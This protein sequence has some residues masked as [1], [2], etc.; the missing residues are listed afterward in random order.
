MLCQKATRD[1]AEVHP[2][3]CLGYS[4]VVLHSIVGAP[5]Q[6]LCNCYRNSWGEEY[7]FK[8][9]R[10]SNHALIPKPWKDC[11]G[12][13]FPQSFIQGLNWTEFSSTHLPI[14][15]HVHDEPVC[16]GCMHIWCFR[17]IDHMHE[18]RRRTWMMTASSHSV[19]GSFLTLGFSW[20]CHLHLSSYC[21]GTQVVLSNIS[22]ITLMAHLSLQLFPERPLMP[23][24]IMDQF[25]VPYALISFVS[26][27]SSWRGEAYTWNLLIMPD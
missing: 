20:L 18:T 16:S 4:P 14:C 1:H 3:L 2:G 8:N 5:W 11:Q 6:Q 17:R 27:A 23:A 19:N 26:S 22:Q 9:W 7:A 13:P 15:C 24:A 10:Q 21:T 25:R 12:H